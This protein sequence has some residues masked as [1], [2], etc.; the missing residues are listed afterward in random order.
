MVLRSRGAGRSPQLGLALVAMCLSGSAGATTLVVDSRTEIYQAGGNPVGGSFNGGID[1]VPFTFSAGAGKT[2]TFSSIQGVLDCD[3]AGSICPQSGPEGNLGGGV[4][5]AAQGDLSGIGFRGSFSTPLLG[6]FLGT[7]LPSGPP[8]ALDF[9]NAENFATLSP[10]VGQVFWVGDG[11][12]G[13]GSG[14]P[15][16]FV[17]PDT[18]TR[19]FLGFYDPQAADNTGQATAEFSIIPEPGTG[20]MVVLGAL[21]VAGAARGRARD[22][23]MTRTPRS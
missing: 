2:L 16:S 15:H 8:P 9:Q 1:P 22:A 3:G 5:L 20:V 21:I 13:T 18:A 14:N 11:L 4:V 19:L 6:V 23:G 17:V 10:L 7:G 12:V